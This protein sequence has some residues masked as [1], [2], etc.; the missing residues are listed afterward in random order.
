MKLDDIKQG[1]GSLWDTVA[2]GC[3]RLRES[4]SSAPKRFKPG[5]ASNLPEGS[6]IDD[7]H[8]LPSHGWA[9]I[10]GDAF[11]DDRRLVVRLEV[12]GMDKKDFDIEVLGDQLVV[13]GEN[14]FERESTDGRWRVM[15]CAYG[16]FRR[17]VPVPVKGDKAR[18][19]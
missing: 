19:A 7:G 5:A 17:S 14:R 13:R 12:P 11:E 16:A 3:G 8:W 10:G 2:G 6:Q 1:F 15:Q 18:A 4:A 9:M